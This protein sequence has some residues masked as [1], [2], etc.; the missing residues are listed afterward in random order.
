M[1]YEIIGQVYKVG[2]TEQIPTKSGNPFQKRTLVLM[3][4]QYDRTTGQ[5]LEPNYPSF[6]F[7]QRGCALLDQFQPNQL[8][9]VT[10]E[11]SGRKYQ[12]KKTGQEDYFTSLRA[13]RIEPY[14]PPQQAQTGNYPPP[15][16]NGYQQPQNGYQRQN[17]QLDFQQQG[18]YPP[19]QGGYPPQQ[20]GYPPPQGYVPASQADDAPF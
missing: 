16:Q 7:T 18:N 5:P 3:Q 1:A 19:Q 11:L 8:V 2:Q 13:F 17:P 10:F 15:A 20:G 6:E 4:Q 12:S 9:K 14:A